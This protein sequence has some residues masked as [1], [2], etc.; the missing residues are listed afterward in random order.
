M[1]RNRFNQANRST[2]RWYHQ[3]TNNLTLNKARGLFLD[4]NDHIDMKDTYKITNV[5]SPIDEKDVVNKEYCDNI[6]LSSNNKIDILSKNITEL[7]K[8]EF[9]KVTTKT[10]QLNET[11][12]NDELINEFIESAN[13]VTNTVKFCNKD[14]VAADTISKYNQLKQDLDNNMFNQ[15]ITHIHLDDMFTNGL[16]E[17]KEYNKSLRKVIVQYIIAILLQNTLVDNKEKARLEVH[18]DFK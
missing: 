5:H 4:D 12:V 9:D 11:Q 10:L 17:M 18:N 15:N 2:G 14:K 13:E 1:T 6:L 3:S 16:R 8:G 7:R